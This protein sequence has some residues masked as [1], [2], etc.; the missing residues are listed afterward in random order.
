MVA[1]S[2]IV[3]DRLISRQ[4]AV[5]DPRRGMRSKCSFQGRNEMSSTA[6]STPSKAQP[7]ARTKIIATVGPACLDPS[8]LT[9][10]VLAGVDV[11]RL[12]MAHGDFSQREQTIAAI[13]DLEVVHGPLG[14]LVDL[15]G[16]KVRLGEIDGGAVMC[17]DGQSFRYA[18]ENAEPQPGDLSCN[19]PN[20]IDELAVGN[21]ILLADGTVAMEVTEVGK[22]FATC[23]VVDDGEI[24]S[25][26]GVAF[27]GANVS[28]PTLTEKDLVAVE[29]AVKQEIDFV[30]LSFVRCADEIIRLKKLIA[31][32]G[33]SFPVIAK[34][35]KGEALENL[36]SIVDVADGV[37]VARGDLGVETDVAEVPVAQKR[38]VK[39][40]NE[41]QKPVIVATQMLDSMQRSP[42]PTRAE[43]TDV[44]NA[45]LDGADA[46]M[47]SGETAIGDYPV[48]AVQM[49]NRI[50]ISTEQLLR[51]RQPL[52]PSR[53]TTTGV[54]PITLSVVYGASRIAEFLDSKLLIVV[55]RSGATALA[56]SHL[57]GFVPTAGVSESMEV[58]RRMS[59]YWGVT[60]L[61]NAPKDRLELQRFVVDWAKERAILQQGD[62]VVL[63]SGT[64]VARNAH[65]TVV[66][67]EAE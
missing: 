4:S 44:A 9:E 36:E 27:P 24:R 21:S 35:E 13:R 52:P 54:L 7:L 62:P 38:I 40:C 15:A 46:C 31:D 8:V 17:S 50:M 16:P 51:D 45:I 67:F 30:S 41:R 61:A 5:D 65:N 12:N 66:V 59:L 57:R 18:N 29:W 1:T 3:I 58:L 25:R 10:L 11:F 34:I 2:D 55:T 28:I 60:P 6:N 39:A 20:V 64:N 22:G 49:M 53:E 14:I 43:S 23:K 37:M 48:E 47:L 26:Q 42:Y 56:R 33:K 19:Y 63:V 32:H